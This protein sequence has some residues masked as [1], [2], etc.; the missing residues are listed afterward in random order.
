MG[1]VG[2]AQTDTHNISGLINHMN[3][4]DNTPEEVGLVMPLEGKTL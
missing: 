4:K 3:D 2:G 1:R